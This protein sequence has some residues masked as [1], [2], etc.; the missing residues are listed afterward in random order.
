[1]SITYTREKN[2]TQE[3]VQE[4]FQSVGWVSANYPERLMKALQHCE[5]VITAWEDHRLVGLINVL[6]DGELT[7]YCHYLLVHKDYHGK[8]I[9]S[10]LLRLIREQYERYLYLILI[11]ENE[12]LVEFYKKN[13]FEQQ[14]NNFVMEIPNKV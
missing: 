12:S 8:G 11:A 10:E 4:L 14:T 7:A 5:T 3:Q 13:G 1:M 9:G 2:F 6:D